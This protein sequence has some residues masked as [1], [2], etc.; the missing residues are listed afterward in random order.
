MQRTPR[1]RHWNGNGHTKERAITCSSETL[2]FCGQTSS[3]TLSDNSWP[4]GVEFVLKTNQFP[5]SSSAGDFSWLH[6]NLFD[7]FPRTWDRTMIAKF[8]LIFSPPEQVTTPRDKVLI[9]KHLQLFPII[10]VAFSS[11][12]AA[13]WRLFLHPTCVQKHEHNINKAS[14]RRHSTNTSEREHSLEKITF[15]RQTLG[16]RRRHD[17]LLLLRWW[18]LFSGVKN[19]VTIFKKGSPN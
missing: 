14:S 3:T 19:F 4:E 8:Y 1:I 11:C 7:R 16:P 10:I 18:S 2:K 6:S 5:V 15:F 13:A 9:L 17:S 12:A